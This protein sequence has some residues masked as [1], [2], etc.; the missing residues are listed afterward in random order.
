MVVPSS[1]SREAVTSSLQDS[2]TEEYALPFQAIHDQLGKS[3]RL[4]AG[5]IIRQLGAETMTSPIELLAPH[6]IG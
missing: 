3:G 2:L 1:S 5:P 4:C 6:G